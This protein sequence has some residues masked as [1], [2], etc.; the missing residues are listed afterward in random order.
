MK[1]LVVV[2]CLLAI[3]SVTFGQTKK[4]MLDKIAQL[5]KSLD[6]LKKVSDNFENIVENRD[7]TLGFCNDDKKKLSEEKLELAKLIKAKDDQI[8]NLERQARMGVTKLMAAGNS[9]SV[10]T[11]PEGKHW[12]INQVITDYAAALTKDSL[13]NTVCEEIHVF[14]KAIDDVVMTDVASGKLG[15]QLYSSTTPEH[16]LNLPLIFTSKTK[17][18]IVIMKGPLDALQVYD[19][20]ISISF[21]ECWNS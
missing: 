21:T 15:P 4:E 2:F 12:I 3:N 9:R 18:S 5:E 20:K 11:V 13:G 1:G 6:S 17:F 10:F 8:F 7:R 19:G 16:C 14:L